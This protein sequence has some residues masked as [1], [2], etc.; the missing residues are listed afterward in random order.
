MKALHSNKHMAI[1]V[2]TFYSTS[3]VARKSISFLPPVE[4]RNHI[5]KKKIPG[6]IIG[7]SSFDNSR[8]GVGE[9]RNTTRCDTMTWWLVR[10]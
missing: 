8:G 1:P 3:Y 10:R 7:R 2:F 6:F 4:G 5:C 9:K